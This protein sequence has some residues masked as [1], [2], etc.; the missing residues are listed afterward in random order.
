MLGYQCQI[1]GVCCGRWR[2][3]VEKQVYKDIKNIFVTKK[4][5][6]GNFDDF[7]QRVANPQFGGDFD[8]G[9]IRLS[10]Q[11][12]CKLQEGKYCYI[13][14]YIGP[15]YLPG[16]CRGFPRLITSTPRGLEF[17]ITPACI[18]AARTFLN[19]TKAQVVIN[20]PDFHFTP[21]SNI[22]HTITAS[23]FAKDDMARNYYVLEEHFMEILQNRNFTIEERMIFLG[24]TINKVMGL[25]A[26]GSF[27]TG[28][29]KLVEENK[30]LLADSAFAGEVKKLPLNMGYQL[31]A[32]KNF[33]NTELFIT[34]GDREVT[35]VVSECADRLLAGE[36]PANI[37][38]YRKMHHYHMRPGAGEVAHVFENY[39]VNF[40]LRKI[41]IIYPLGD[42]F[43]ILTFFYVII[44][45]LALC[46]A[47]G[48]NKVV[49]GETVVRAMHLIEKT[50]GH[51]R[52]HDQVLAQ[53][54]EQNR[55]DTAHAIGLIRI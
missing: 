10:D 53:L 40:V 38:A 14:K 16:V 27:K 5:P 11:G 1:C 33:L 55:A 25:P 49:D 43:Y 34:C 31:I 20:P 4:I 21:G 52:L 41:F 51:T 26:G 13:H 37:T 46:L 3:F 54:K 30:A 50:L 36:M 45:A 22:N 42:A 24:L 48:E 6:F 17:A 29:E 12:R 9:I 15:E 19:K 8:Y 18:Y 7:F 23:Y 28:L 44:R 2:I 32:L 35:E 47:A 39:L